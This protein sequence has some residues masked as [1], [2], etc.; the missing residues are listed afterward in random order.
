MPENRRQWELESVRTVRTQAALA[1]YAP[2]ERDDEGVARLSVGGQSTEAGAHV[3]MLM[4]ATSPEGSHIN[5]VVVGE[6]QWV[7]E[8]ERP[9]GDNLNAVD[10]LN[11][12]TEAA[13]LLWPYLR[14]E[15]QRAAQ[16]I[17]EAVHFP[18]EMP[19]EAIE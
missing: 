7:G 6:L 1:R 18:P 4:K 11:A 8:G 14:M 5:V 13:R 2:D 15:V 9:S 17:G 3:E 10:N 12:R 19:P 16:A